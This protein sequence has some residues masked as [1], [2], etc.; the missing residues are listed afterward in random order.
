M[1]EKRREILEERVEDLLLTWRLKW[2]IVDFNLDN[3]LI[4]CERE[5]KARGI[6][7]PLESWRRRWYNSFSTLQ[8]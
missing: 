6:V 1:R 5:K 4:E 2:L 3:N 7:F 8:N